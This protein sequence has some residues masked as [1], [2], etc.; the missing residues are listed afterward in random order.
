M[1]TVGENNGWVI[2]DLICIGPTE[3]Y[4]DLEYFTITNIHENHVTLNTTVSKFHYG[5]SS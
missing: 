1:I 5:A 3:N 4:D 2:G